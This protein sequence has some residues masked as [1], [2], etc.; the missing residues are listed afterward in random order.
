M[1]DTTPAVQLPRTTSSRARNM[2]PSRIHAGLATEN[3]LG[4]PCT[5]QGTT[6]GCLAALLAASHVPGRPAADR[7]VEEDHRVRHVVGER[8]RELFCGGAAR[9]TAR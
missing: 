6:L 3:A 5:R 2:L 8:E 9:G 1:H 7:H 4:S